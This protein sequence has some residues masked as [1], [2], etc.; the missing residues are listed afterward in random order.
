MVKIQLQRTRVLRLHYLTPC[1]PNDITISWKGSS[2]YPS[3]ST[4][5]RDISACLFQPT[6]NTDS[7]HTANRSSCCCHGNSILPSLLPWGA[8]FNS[9]TRQ[10]ETVSQRVHPCNS[11]LRPTHTSFTVTLR[12]VHY[13]THSTQTAIFYNAQHMK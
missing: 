13:C 1:P 7:I 9:I 4:N 3:C 5:G 11:V 2:H 8:S 12:T 6:R 10:G